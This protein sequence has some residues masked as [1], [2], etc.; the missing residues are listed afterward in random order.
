M[1]Q[2][3]TQDPSGIL[4]RYKTQEIL[5]SA[6]ELGKLPYVK[7]PHL[8][9]LDEHNV[10]IAYKRGTRHNTEPA[11]D[12]EMFRY[13]P[14]TGAISDRKIVA[15]LDGFTIQNGEFARFSNGDI[16]LYVD[17]HFPDSKDK[18]GLLVYRSLDS[19]AHFEGGKKLGPINGTEYVYAFECLT[20]GETT[21]MLLTPYRHYQ[22]GSSNVDV[23][24]SDDNGKSWQFVANLTEAFGNAPI[25]ETSCIRYEDGYIFNTRGLDGIQRMHFTDE[26]F[27][28]I[29]EVN[30]TETYKFI[31]A[32]IGRPRLFER[33]GGFYFIGRNGMDNMPGR[34]MKLCL[35]KF[36][37]ESLEILYYAILDNYEGAV[38]PDGYY[39]M[40][41]F[42]TRDGEVYFNVITYKSLHFRESPPDLI[43]LEFRWDELR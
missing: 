15:H 35:F 40:P 27:R 30:L 16:G 12:W 19:G 26:A 43:R 25:N 33:D 42:I 37:P 6:A 28:L 1:I 8:L 38:V 17:P 41:Y 10:L 29:R 13:N 23:V 9:F 22:N 3:H 21:W 34:G 14:T 20:E 4:P 31:R 2:A 39:A 24:R 36:D 5:V 7:A 11:A 32:Q 18:F